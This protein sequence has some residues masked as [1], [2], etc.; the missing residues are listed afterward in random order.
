M[1][2]ELYDS[3]LPFAES[4]T[5]GL[6]TPGQV[7]TGQLSESDW[8]PVRGATVSIA[9]NSWFTADILTLLS[10]ATVNETRLLGLAW[11]T[12]DLTKGDDFY[13]GSYS[14]LIGG[15]LGGELALDTSCAISDGLGAAVG[16]MLSQGLPEMEARV[17]IVNLTD[18]GDFIA[19]PAAARGRYQRI[20]SEGVVTVTASGCLGDEVA[21][22]TVTTVREP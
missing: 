16:A 7:F 15:P 11:G 22:F 2:Q 10:D 6:L 19:G 12:F 17:A 13:Q 9:N 18:R 8:E 21:T 3:V 14:L 20:G 1:P 4:N 5:P